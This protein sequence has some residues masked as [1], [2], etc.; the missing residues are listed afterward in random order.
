MS[1]RVP[2]RSVAQMNEIPEVRHFLACEDITVSQSGIR[3][4]LV[5][6][7]QT[8]H[9]QPGD[10]FPLLHTRTCLYTLLTNGRGVHTFAVELVTGVPGQ[11]TVIGTSAPMRF[12][13][14]QDPLVLYALPLRLPPI[15]FDQPGQYEFRLLCDGQ[16]IAHEWIEVRTS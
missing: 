11:E 9:P 7:F 2:V 3:H 14:G 8:L 12:D 13:L 5:E 10:T 4:T 6:V 16:V 15:R 1:V